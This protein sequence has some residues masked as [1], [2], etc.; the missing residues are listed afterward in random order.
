MILSC[1]DFLSG[2]YLREKMIVKY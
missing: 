2:L 1:L